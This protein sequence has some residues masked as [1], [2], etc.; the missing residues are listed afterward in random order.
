MKT[1]ITT[2][3][4]NAGDYL[5][6]I[7][8][9]CPPEQAEFFVVTQDGD[10]LEND[11][12][13]GLLLTRKGVRYAQDTKMQHF[14]GM[15]FVELETSSQNPEVIALKL[16]NPA[17][18]ALGSMRS[19][20][21]AAAAKENGKKGGRPKAAWHKAPAR[22]CTNTLAETHRFTIVRLSDKAERFTDRKPRKSPNIMIWDNRENCEA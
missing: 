5:A 2:I 13:W 6:T 22:G 11:K 1:A 12:I 16:L 4:R 10:K 9:V 20:K 21:K 18:V 8:S 7:A 14:R 3:Q 19:E 17:A 15:A